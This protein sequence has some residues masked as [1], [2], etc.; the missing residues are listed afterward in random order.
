MAPKGLLARYMNIDVDGW[1]PLG[2][3]GGIYRFDLESGHV[4][5]LKP[6]MPP[7]PAGVWRIS[8]VLVTPDRRH[9]AYSASRWM[10]NLYVFEGLH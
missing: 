10:S 3:P 9:Y 4:S 2:V 6:L 8:P 7:N 1:V 5:L